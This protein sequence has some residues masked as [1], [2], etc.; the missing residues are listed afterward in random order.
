MARQRIG[1]QWC[2]P[3]VS[4]CEESRSLAMNMTIIQVKIRPGD[5]V[6]AKG[7]SVQCQGFG[8]YVTADIQQRLTRS[9]IQSRVDHQR[10]FFVS[11]TDFF[12][13]FYCPIERL[14][15]IDMHVF[16]NVYQSISSRFRNKVRNFR[17]ALCFCVMPQA[18]L[19]NI[20]STPF[21]G[22]K[23]GFQ[24]CSSPDTLSCFDL[25]NGTA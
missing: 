1:K 25:K 21:T 3:N 16:R 24:T 18:K 22:Q 20:E 23:L 6:F 13:Q 10:C 11:Y 8:T 4:R 9:G 19:N 15:K 7:L 2:E 12:A 5:H 14:K 17:F